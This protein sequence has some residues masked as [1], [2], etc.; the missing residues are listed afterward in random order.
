MVI[1]LSDNQEISLIIIEEHFTSYEVFLVK[2]KVTNTKYPGQNHDLVVQI[3]VLQALPPTVSSIHKLR[4]WWTIF[5]TSCVTVPLVA[6]KY[7]LVEWEENPPRLLTQANKNSPTRSQVP[8]LY[9]TYVSSQ[10][11][12]CQNGYCFLAVSTLNREVQSCSEIKR[13]PN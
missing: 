12:V 2:H 5:L 13:T 7:L 10:L 8:H 9:L 4:K 3:L 11:L 1:V 6:L